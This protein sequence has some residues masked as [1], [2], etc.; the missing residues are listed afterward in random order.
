LSLPFVNPLRVPFPR[1]L[2]SLGLFPCG[3]SLPDSFSPSGVRTG[4]D[5]IGEGRIGGD[6]M[7]GDPM[8][9]GLNCGD[10]NEGVLDCGDAIPLSTPYVFM[11]LL[12]SNFLLNICP[13]LDERALSICGCTHCQHSK[14]QYLATEKRLLFS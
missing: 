4:E 14:P 13:I 10:L 9:D 3:R 8:G 12:S 2:A 1:P 6:P 11:G 7:A 5:R